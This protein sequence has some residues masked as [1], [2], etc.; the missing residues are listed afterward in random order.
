MSVCGSNCVGPTGNGLDLSEARILPVNNYAKNF[1]RFSTCPLGLDE[2]TFSSHE[3]VHMRRCRDAGP[4]V[5]P[6]EEFQVCPYW[7]PPSTFTALA[8]PQN[9]AYVRME[10]ANYVESS[11]VSGG[12]AK[13]NATLRGSSYIANVLKSPKAVE[14]YGTSQLWPS[15]IDVAFEETNFCSANSDCPGSYCNLRPVPHKC[16]PKTAK[17]HAGSGYGF[18]DHSYTH[19]AG[20]DTAI[21]ARGSSGSGGWSGVGST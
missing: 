13:G 20:G 14:F 16:A 5:P 15:T 11:G 10:F 2:E 3:V 1:L 7:I 12:G 4:G 9:S 18:K 17:H 21:P 8:I 6:E 19:G